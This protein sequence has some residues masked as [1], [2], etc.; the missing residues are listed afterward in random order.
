MM[1]SF[2]SSDSTK[3]G[4][5][6]VYQDS[7]P[8]GMFN[9]N[10]PT[11]KGSHP[12]FTVGNKTSSGSI[13]NHRSSHTQY[14]NN[15]SDF[16]NKKRNFGGNLLGTNQAVFGG[17]NCGNYPSSNVALFENLR[18]LGSLKDLSGAEMER[19]R[20]WSERQ[21]VLNSNGDGM[22]SSILPVLRALAQQQA[23]GSSN[24]E[25]CNQI[26]QLDSIVNQ[27][28]EASCSKVVGECLSHIQLLEE[29]CTLLMRTCQ[30][31]ESR[32]RLMEQRMN[33]MQRR[34]QKELEGLE[35]R[36]KRYRNC[37]ACVQSEHVSTAS[38]INQA[39]WCIQEL[40]KMYPN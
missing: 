38:T 31:L 27:L 26:D 28:K 6:Q 16:P 19:E 37:L 18:L 10:N 22:G 12:V 39:E 34:H 11:M 1:E 2:Q 17:S 4:Q 5:S 35:G 40:R 3:V 15:L 21:E 29:D 7:I 33:D 8:Q 9:I 32:C 13:S 36:L 24:E 30:E 23:L 20:K 14:N 25:N